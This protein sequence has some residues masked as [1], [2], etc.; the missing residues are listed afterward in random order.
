MYLPFIKPIVT[1]PI[2]EA[3]ELLREDGFFYEPGDVDQ[4]KDALSRALDVEDWEPTVD[5]LLTAQA[6]RRWH[7]LPVRRLRFAAL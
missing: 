5:P 2:G 7:L 6:W 1:S 4:L 3:L